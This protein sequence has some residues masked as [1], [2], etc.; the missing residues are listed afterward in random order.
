MVRTSAR[1]TPRYYRF[2]AVLY[3]AVGSL[4]DVV[5][6][7]STWTQGHILE[8]WGAQKAE[9]VFPPCDTHGLTSLGVQGRKPHII[10]VAQFR[11]PRPSTTN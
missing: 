11:Y 3:G 2:F 4:A 1:L 9:V 5:M 7:N 6:V 10:S 8:L